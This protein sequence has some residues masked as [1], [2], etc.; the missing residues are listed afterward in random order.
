M[1]PTRP[2]T[3]ERSRR[4]EE[5]GVPVFCLSLCG[6]AEVGVLA[7]VVQQL[8]RRS[9]LP[10]RW[11]CTQS[12]EHLLMDIQIAALSEREGDLL[13]EVLRQIVGIE[14]VL[15]ARLLRQCAA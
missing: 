7:R 5:S 2:G 9:L 6:A 4:P 10:L 11:H 14:E 8:A 1:L 15:T 12:G 13:A 3:A